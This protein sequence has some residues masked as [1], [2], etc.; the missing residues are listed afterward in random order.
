MGGRR[1]WVS[2]RA[3]RG[4]DNLLGKPQV[5]F[6]KS[7]QFQEAQAHPACRI[8]GGWIPS[9]KDWTSFGLSKRTRGH[10]YQAERR[11]AWGGGNPHC[12]PEKAMSHAGPVCSWM[13]REEFERQRAVS[14]AYVVLS[15]SSHIHSSTHP[16]NTGCRFVFRHI[17]VHCCHTEISATG[18][19]RRR[20]N[21][22]PLPLAD[23]PK[24]MFD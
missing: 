22:H 14:C 20:R 13:R 5:S 9:R 11:R 7:G 2:E 23:I 1:R 19:R 18:C 12:S 6:Q 15:D 3:E 8:P 10:R 17:S 16:R 21:A 4:L 24:G